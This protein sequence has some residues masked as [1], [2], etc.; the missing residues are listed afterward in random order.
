M[1]TSPKDLGLHDKKY[2]FKIWWDHLQQSGRDN[3]VSI[4]KESVYVELEAYRLQGLFLAAQSNEELRS[5]RHL[6]LS[7]YASCYGANPIAVDKFID[8]I[9]VFSQVEHL[10]IGNCLVVPKQLVKLS[11]LKILEFKSRQN[12]NFDPTVGT[13]G[14]YACH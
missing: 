4:A 1:A 6:D 10:N 8:Q 9:D 7:S 3:W 2:Q 11:N 12:R 5:I 13:R 14:P